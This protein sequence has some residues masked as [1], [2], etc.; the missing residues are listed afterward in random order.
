MGC[1]ELVTFRGGFVA[2][3]AV[4]VRI[5]NLEARGATFTLINGGRFRVEPPVVLTADDCAFLRER[6]DEAR[7]VLEY[8][9]QLAAEASA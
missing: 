9:E 2:D 3:L 7:S 5:L 6:R 4:V 8:V 1:S